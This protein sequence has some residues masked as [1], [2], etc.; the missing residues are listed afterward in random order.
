[1][2]KSSL[3]TAVGVLAVILMAGSV[4]AQEPIEE[5]EV[6]LG[7]TDLIDI[8]RQAP[9]LDSFDSVAAFT[10]KRTGALVRCWAYSHNRILIGRARTRV[11]PRGVRLI[12][13]SHMSGGF[14]FVGQIRCSSGGDIST[15]AFL[16][17]PK[18]ITNLPVE[19]WNHDGVDQFRI[20]INASF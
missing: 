10:S 11:P 18:D 4:S 12:R 13:A 6:D 1:M 9:D 3:H 17:G 7:P 19:E 2:T 8:V 20:P 14:D 15:T 5:L 16:V